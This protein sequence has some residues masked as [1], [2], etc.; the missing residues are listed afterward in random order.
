MPAITQNISPEIHQ[1]LEDL[2]DEAG[3][4]I[5]SVLLRE[6]MI[7]RL[8]KR[9]DKLLSIRFAQHLSDE[10]IQTFMRMNENNEPKEKI[11]AF[12]REKIPDVEN[13]VKDTFVEFRLLYLEGY[14][15]G[16]K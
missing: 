11:D 2:M 12:L 3:V 7:S 16:D 13:V 5:A 6:E 8:V 14:K 1:F 15:K 10:D 4:V 9:L